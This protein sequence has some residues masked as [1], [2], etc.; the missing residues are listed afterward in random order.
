MFSLK[1]FLT[2]LALL[3]KES[4]SQLLEKNDTSG[5]ASANLDSFIN[6]T[7]KSPIKDSSLLRQASS[8]VTYSCDSNVQT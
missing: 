5:Q 8:S 7:Y 1:F 3:L 6:S 4:S 2:F